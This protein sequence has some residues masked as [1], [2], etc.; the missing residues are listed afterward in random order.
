L[1]RTFF[2]LLP[3]QSLHLPSDSD[4]L[5]NQVYSNEPLVECY[6]LQNQEIAQEIKKMAHKAETDISQARN[7]LIGD[8][9]WTNAF[10]QST[11][12]SDD[13]TVS[14]TTRALTRNII[15]PSVQ[16]VCF[17]RQN[18]RTCLLDGGIPYDPSTIPPHGL[19]PNLL[20]SIVT[21]NKQATVAY[22]LHQSPNKAWRK[23]PALRGTYPVIFEDGVCQ[24][25]YGM[26]LTLD[27]DRGLVIE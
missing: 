11:Y 20:R 12:L 17:T 7:Y 8:V 13:Q 1:L 2:T 18:G 16:I 27:Q 25:D 23:L 3:L 24:L 19:L 14:E 4:D 26:R 15:L 5:I 10:S 6:E 9:D 21:L 22:F